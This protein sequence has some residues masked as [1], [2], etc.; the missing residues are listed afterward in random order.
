[1]EL[2]EAQLLSEEELKVEDKDEVPFGIRAIESGIQVDG[3]WISRNNTPAGSVTSSFDE[4]RETSHFRT[5]S[6]PEQ[7]EIPQPAYGHSSRSSST[8]ANS[9]IERAVSAERIPSSSQSSHSPT[10]SLHNERDT[11]PGALDASLTKNSSTLLAL[12]GFNSWTTP[13]KLTRCQSGHLL[14]DTFQIALV[15]PNS[16]SSTTSSDIST[17]DSEEADYRTTSIPQ[18]HTERPYEPAYLK[19]ITAPIIAVDSKWNVDLL[20]SHRLSH[21][22]ETGQLAPRIRRPGV[23]GDWTD[24]VTAPRPVG[25]TRS[26]IEHFTRHRKSSSML[27]SS[28]LDLFPVPPQ[29]SSVPPSARE[30]HLSNLPSHMVVPP[31]T[32]RPRGDQSKAYTSEPLKLTQVQDVYQLGAPDQRHENQI[33]PQEPDPQPTSTAGHNRRESQVLRKVNSGF[34]ILRPGSLVFSNQLALD[35]SGS[36]TSEKR[37]SRRLRKKRWS[38]GDYG[39]PPSMDIV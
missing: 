12:E 29:R 4:S 18:L 19:P 35:D 1:V 32:Y 24:I 31:N 26:E 14:T 28:Q 34:V 13:C 37:Q 10:Q 22:A 2:L 36:N 5:R 25:A 8:L 3:V 17:H 11:R 7:L 15:E 9:A 6:D 27:L 23:S 39:G 21:V 33:D 38:S 30:S 20:Q 16:S